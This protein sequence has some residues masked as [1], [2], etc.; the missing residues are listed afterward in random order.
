MNGISVLLDL[1][2]LP[3]GGVINP[4]FALI[5]MASNLTA[6]A[7]TLLAMASNLIAMDGNLIAMART[8]AA[9]DS[10]GLHPNSHGR[11]LQPNSD[12]LQ[13][14]TDGLETIF[15]WY[16]CKQ[17]IG[18]LTF[19]GWLAAAQCI[20][21]RCSCSDYQEGQ[22]LIKFCYFTSMRCL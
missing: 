21:P 5:A 6:M 22:M 12:R 13:P 11:G 15:Q 2:D 8:L 17:G 9:P 19:R 16:S 3:R 7:C 1:L 10:D 4:V 14:N 18:R 20:V